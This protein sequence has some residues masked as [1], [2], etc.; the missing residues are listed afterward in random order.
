MIGKKLATTI[1]KCT[2]KL[3]Q[4]LE[5]A[6]EQGAKTIVLYLTDPLLTVSGVDFVR[7]KLDEDTYDEKIPKN[8][9]KE[10]EPIA[11]KVLAIADQLYEAGINAGM[12]IEIIEDTAKKIGLDV[13]HIL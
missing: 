5:K 10:L 9:I 2:K 11:G 13:F 3:L 1:D 4:L 12:V 6:K 7:C 8:I